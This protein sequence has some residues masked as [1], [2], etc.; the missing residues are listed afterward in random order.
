MGTMVDVTPQ[1]IAEQATILRAEVGSAV[2]GLAL[3]G[4][5]DRDEMGICIE[6]VTHVIGLEHFE[7]YTYRTQP[8]GVRSGPGDLDLTV[9]S[10]RKWCRLALKGN[11]TVLLLLFTPESALVE[12]KR[13]GDELQQLASAF[14]SRSA[15]AAFLGY[16]TAQKQ[17]LLG[18]RGQMRVTRADLIKRHG[19]DTKYAGH[20]LRLGYQG[21]EFLETGRMSLP[22]R[23][24]ERSHILAVRRGEVPLQDVLTDCGLLECRLRDLRTDSP[25]PEQP[26]YA[27]VNDFLQYAYQVGW[28]LTRGPEVERQMIL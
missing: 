9:Y 22:M 16:L 2:H 4:S 3:E 15:G 1:Q 21:C 10:L 18:E 5:S 25:L 12:R 8:E 17:R 28:L 14:A 6:P 27:A 13:L 20:M 24:A 23:E 26:D 11:P 7:Q 19:F